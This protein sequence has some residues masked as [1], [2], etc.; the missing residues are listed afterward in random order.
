MLDSWI[1]YADGFLLIY[2]IDDKESFEA[3][4]HRYDRIVKSKEEKPVII[5]IGNKCDL[6]DKRK[7]ERSEGEEFAKSKGIK[8]MEV[9]ALEKI[10]V[11]DAFLAVA[12]ELLYKQLNLNIHE[13]RKIRKRCYCF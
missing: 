1:S 7:V 13:D 8:F 12:S 10:N 9:S 2:A 11:K 4:R 6:V 3:T 5:L